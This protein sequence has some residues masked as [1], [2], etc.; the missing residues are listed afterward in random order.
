MSN[1][2][3][4]ERGPL[5]ETSLDQKRIAVLVFPAVEPCVDVLLAAWRSYPSCCVCVRVRC[6]SRAGQQHQ[7]HG[8]AADGASQRTSRA[9]G[10]ALEEE[11]VRDRP[12]DHGAAWRALGR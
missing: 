6:E 9:A 4:K 10:A 2:L 5:C 8:A 11:R 1:R 12:K 3:D 7:A